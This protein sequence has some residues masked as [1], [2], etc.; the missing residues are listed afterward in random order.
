M[1]HQQ[2]RGHYAGHFLLAAHAAR[3]IRVPSRFA[4]DDAPNENIADDQFDADLEV[5]AIQELEAADVRNDDDEEVVV[6]APVNAIRIAVNVPPENNG[7]DGDLAPV[8][9]FDEVR[10]EQVADRK[11]RQWPGRIANELHENNADDDARPSWVRR[12]LEQHPDISFNA[13]FTQFKCPCDMSKWRAISNTGISNINKHLGKCRVRGHIDVNQA[14]MGAD[15]RVVPAIV[16]LTQASFEARL[17]TATASAALPF[18][19]V[20]NPEVKELFR[21]ATR[22]AITMPSRRTLMRRV[23]DNFDLTRAAVRKSV[24]GATSKI[25]LTFDCWT[26]RASRSFIAVTAHYY[27]QYCVLRSVLLDMPHIPFEAAGHTGERIR[28][29]IL[30]VLQDE[31]GES[32]RT[33]LGFL[34]TDNGSNVVKAALLLAHATNSVARRCLQHN[35]QLFLKHLCAGEPS[36]ASPIASANYLARLTKVSHAFHHAVGSIPV[37]VVTRWN[38]YIDSAS[39]VVSKRAEIIAYKNQLPPNN[40]QAPMLEPH[41]RSLEDFGGFTAL[42]DLVVLLEPLMQI[43]IEQEG[44]YRVTSSDVVP[45]LVQAKEKIDNILRCVRTRNNIGGLI[46]NCEL[47]TSWAP[48]IESLWNTYI[49]GFT[50]DKIFLCAMWFDARHRCAANLPPWVSAEA[51]DAVKDLMTTAREQ[52]IA[53]ERDLAA[54]QQQPANQ[55]HALPPADANAP[56]EAQAVDPL[57]HLRNLGII[58]EEP[59]PVQQPRQLDLPTVEDEFARIS[60]HLATLVLPANLHLFDPM[61]AFQ[62][63]EY[64]IS[65]RVALNVFSMPAGDAPSPSE[66]IFSIAGRILTPSRARLAANNLSRTTYMMKNRK[67]LN[68][69]R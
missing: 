14:S 19:W 69:P 62:A 22:G 64:P 50:H 18:A 41:L 60:R 47:V 54:A 33:R 4:E 3:E 25:S 37:G 20:D 61:S 49:H 7:G 17:V 65:R 36:I 34:V 28:D 66:R 68:M 26:D 46:A 23:D 8:R 39:K 44:E 15:G 5:V 6:A 31:I 2:N 52:L 42:R 27:D 63:A 67:S 45:K 56:V 13:D 48:K 1:T 59:V 30:R 35:M 57:A 10:A 24:S 40:R 9:N 29:E 16:Q 51:I 12:T 53:A 32:F 43:A 58:R 55:D 21:H 38:S 11:R